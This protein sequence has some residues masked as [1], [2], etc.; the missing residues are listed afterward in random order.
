[1]TGNLDCILSLSGIMRLGQPVESI[2]LP[3][4]PGSRPFF[5]TREGGAPS[6]RRGGIALFHTLHHRRGIP[7]LGF[8][9]QQM[10]MLGHHY[11]AQHHEAML[12][13]HLFQNLHGQIALLVRSEPRFSLIGASDVVQLAGS[14]LSPEAFWQLAM[15]R[16]NASGRCDG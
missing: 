15:L 5:G 3:G 1:M 10:K 9:Y 6:P 11:V 13:A 4:A 7:H 16:A 8:A 2:C 12:L 14:V